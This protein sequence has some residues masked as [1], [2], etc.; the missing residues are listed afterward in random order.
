[1]IR[2]M[3]RARRPFAT[4]CGVVAAVASCRGGSAPP[5]GGER[6]PVRFAEVAVASGIDFRHDSGAVGERWMLEILGSGAAAFDCDGDGDLDLLLRQAGPLPQAREDSLTPPAGSALPTDRLYRN[7]TFRDASGALVW[8]FADVT[9]GSGLDRPA[10]GMG[11]ATGDVDG[12]GR[13]DLYLTNYGANRL[14]RATGD[15]R[16]VDR[17]AA[18]GVANDGWSSAASFFDYDRDGDLDLFAGNYVDFTPANRKRCLQPGGGL[19]YCGPESHAALPSKLYRNR[20]DGTFDNV[21]LAAG[22]ARAQGKTLGSTAADFD[23]DGWIDLFVANDSTENHL[24]RNRRD[25]TFEE[26][27]QLRGCALNATGLRTGDMGVDA[28]DY[29]DDGDLDLLATHLAIEGMSLWRNDG[30]SGF[31]DVAARTRSLAATLGRTGFGAL[32][33][34]PDSD[35]ALDI[36]IVN[37]A[38]R[39]VDR[40]DGGSAEPTLA[41]PNL[42]LIRKGER[43]DVAARECGITTGEGDVG[44]GLVAADFDDDGD[45]DLAITNNGGPARLLRNDLPGPEAWIGLRLLEAS[46][47]RDALGAVVTLDRLGAASLTRR[48]ATD[49]SYLSARD[50]RLLFGLRG[51]AAGAELRVRWPSGRAESFPVPPLGRYSTLREGTGRPL[52]T[53]AE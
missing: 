51:A 28:A 50:P 9:A 5:G 10:Y 35:G 15:C 34:D 23:G 49:G 27:A 22:L 21:T 37:G 41:E 45:P 8:R 39:L 18:A 11:V 46:G 16:F 13:V 7:D 47:M 30:E 36:A 32:W 14:L 12:D 38:V 4:V 44:R 25:G 1:M 20:G 43:Y 6:P 29:D 48:V 31:Q 40:M 53:P 2:P 3:K 17:T 42:L 26:Q 52:A 33:F 24:W 19:D